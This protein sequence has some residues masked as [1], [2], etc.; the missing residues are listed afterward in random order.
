MDEPAGNAKISTLSSTDDIRAGATVIL[1]SV[2]D[3]GSDI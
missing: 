2:M 1:R 3:W